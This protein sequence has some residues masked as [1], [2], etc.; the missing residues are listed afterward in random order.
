VLAQQLLGRARAEIGARA[1]GASSRLLELAL[2]HVAARDSSGQMLD[3]HQ[4][5]QWMLADCAIEID[6]ARWMTYA[7]VARADAGDD[8]RVCD[9]MVKVFSSEALGRVADRV[10]QLFGGWGYSKD[11]PIER[12]YR[13][14]RMWRIVEGPN[15]VHRNAIARAMSRAGIAAVRP[16]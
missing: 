9:S 10:L 6:A 2:S 7:A 15:E 1:V 13:E 11:F 16:V 3:Q 4:G 14:A 12:F 5:V 8:T